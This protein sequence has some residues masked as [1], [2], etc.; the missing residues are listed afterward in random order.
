MRLLDDQGEPG[1]RR[2]VRGRDRELWIA[3]RVDPLIPEP[4]QVLTRGVEDRLAQIVGRGV[5][6]GVVDQIA[7]DRRPEPLGAEVA[8]QHA[9]HQGSLRVDVVRPQRGERHTML[10]VDLHELVVLVQVIVVLGVTAQVCGPV[11]ARHELREPFVEPHV[12]PILRG[13]VVTEP[14][15]GQLVRDQDP[16]I[17]GPVRVGALVGKPV[18]QGRGADVLHATEE[19]GDRRLGVLGPWITDAGEAGVHVDHVGCE[20][21]QRPGPRRVFA[22]DVIVD[23]RGAPHVVDLH[24][25]RHDQ[26]HE[27]GGTRFVLPPGHGARPVGVGAV[28]G[29]RAVG[30][31]AVASRHRGLERP[32]HLVVGEVVGG[33]PVVVVVVLSLAPDLSRTMGPSLGVD[34]REPASVLDLPMVG[35]RESRGVPEIDRPGQIDDERVAMRGFAERPPGSIGD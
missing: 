25:R 10:R 8:L 17:P 6:V 30:N 11:L 27:I 34:E 14:L 33:E 32:G 7:V 22:I 13:H 2:I 24:E 19:V 16:P 5:V 31:G 9:Q 29:E 4:A 23:R 28:H 12:G 1:A 18:D 35:D 15:V 3:R 21:K 20:A 26:R